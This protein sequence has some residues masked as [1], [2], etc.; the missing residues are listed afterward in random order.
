LRVVTE[1]MDSADIELAMES[2][3]DDY[4]VSDALSGYLMSQLAENPALGQVFDALFE[5]TE[6]VLRLAPATGYQVGDTT[7][8]DL[9]TAAQAKGE[10]AL[11]YLRTATMDITLNPAKSAPVTLD[12]GDRVVVISRS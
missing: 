9:V 2:G 12:E 5:G 8:R 1:L 11:G 6:V 7:F 10:V 4:V 3:G